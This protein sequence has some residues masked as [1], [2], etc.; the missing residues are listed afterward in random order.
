MPTTTKLILNSANRTS[1]TPEKCRYILRS[2]GIQAISY[3]VKKVEIPHS[4]YNITNNNNIIN[5]NDNAGIN[6]TSTL[7]NGNY[8]VDELLTHMGTVMTSGS[9]GA[10]TYTASKNSIT[11]KLSI[12]NNL[13]ITFSIDWS[14]TDETK[15]LAYDLG[16]YPTPHIED[17]GRPLPIGIT[18]Q[19]THSANNSYWIGAPKNIL[20]KSNLAN[21]AKKPACNTL[22]KGGGSSNI[23]E[24]VLVN[25]VS[26]Q[27]TTVEFINPT[28]VPIRS[29]LSIYDIDFELLDENFE[30]LN[31]NGMD[32][33]IHIEFTLPDEND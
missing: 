18:G 20:I 28:V 33:S 16:Y 12:T 8:S 5:W 13:G 21:R 1:G 9:T 27:I 30:L 26:G 24:Q 32:W 7:T 29:N 2:P 25:T 3:Q 11:K 31:L 14:A 19:S 15:Q 17:N 23:L 4:F 6:I 10:E 22:A